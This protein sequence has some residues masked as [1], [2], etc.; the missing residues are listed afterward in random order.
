MVRNTREPSFAQDEE[1]VLYSQGGFKHPFG[2]GWKLGH[3]YLTNKRLLFFQPSGTVYET[4]LCNITNVAVEK[5]KFVLATKDVICLTYRHVRTGRPVKVWIVMGDLG[6]WRKKL[7]ELILIDEQAVDKVA[8]GLDLSCSE[9]LWYL[10]E[11]RHAPIDELAQLVDA[12]NHMDVLLKIK[13]V[14]NPVAERAIGSPILSFER[15]R[16]DYETGE[17]VLFSWW[18]AGRKQAEERKDE[19]LVDVFDEGEYLTVVM[20]LAGVQEKDIGLDVERDK[21]TVS[22]DTPAREYH[23]RIALPTLVSTDGFTTRYNN[24]IL[25]VRLRK[26]NG[27]R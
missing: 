26:G 27:S 8:K 7:S 16:V 15:S 14:V 9:I 10:W 2:S 5:H 13:G 11:H 25:E 6:T 22:V 24:N 3:H 4:P 17:R 21:L 12:P 23:E 20:E 18:L 19:P 1:I